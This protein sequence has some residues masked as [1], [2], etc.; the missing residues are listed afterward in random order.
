MGRVTNKTALTRSLETG[1]IEFCIFIIMTASKKTI[2]NIVE[3]IS[4]WGE[5]LTYPLPADQLILEWEQVLND[6]LVKNKFKEP[7]CQKNLERVKSSTIDLYLENNKEAVKKE[8]AQQVKL[9][10]NDIQEK[11]EGITKIKD[12]LEIVEQASADSTERFKRI[13]FEFVGH[14]KDQKDLEKIVEEFEEELIQICTVSKPYLFEQINSIIQEESLKFFQRFQDLVI[15][16]IKKTAKEQYAEVM[17]FIEIAQ[18]DLKVFADEEFQGFPDVWLKHYNKLLENQIIE[19]WMHKRD[20]DFQSLEANFRTFLQTVLQKIKNQEIVAFDSSLC[21]R[22]TKEAVSEV[23]LSFFPDKIDFPCLTL[24]IFLNLTGVSCEEFIKRFLRNTK[25]LDSSVSKFLD[26]SSQISRFFCI[27]SLVLVFSNTYK[28]LSDNSRSTEDPFNPYY[29]QLIRL[30]VSELFQL[31]Y[32]SLFHYKQTC[33]EWSLVLICEQ[34]I[35]GCIPNWMIEDNVINMT[36][37]IRTNY[38]SKVRN[39]SDRIEDY[40]NEPDKNKVLQKTLQITSKFFKS[41][42]PSKRIKQFSLEKIK[43][44][45]SL[46]TTIVI[47]GWLSQEDEMEESWINLISSKLQGHTFALRWDS[48]SSKKMVKKELFSTVIHSI[49]FIVA[50]PILKVAHLA[51]LFSS[52][53]FKKRAKK[54]ETTGY[55]LADLIASKRLGNAC[56]NLVGFS[57]GTRVIY[58]CLQ[59]LREIGC[60]VNDVLLLGGAAPLDVKVWEQ[61][62]DVVTGR[63]VNTFSKTDKVLSKLYSISRLEKAIGNWPL[64]VKGV[65]NFDVT[66]EASG[67]LKYRE[68]IDKILVKIDYFLR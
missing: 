41:F 37:F 20:D 5:S 38:D 9:I 62:K 6:Q 7:L 27:I 31:N 3:K 66:D 33:N 49:G 45:P 46:T 44:C 22:E 40:A 67:H 18:R 26:N 23:V 21:T 50:A 4:S 56:V 60:C 39:F 28:V 17:G 68:N 34:E 2:K 64:M 55:V 25:F 61:C 47:S 8:L 52:N 19:Y 1:I 32:E 51:W 59:R 12:F 11:S 57:L 15:E 65:E 29:R 43:N 54:A 14:E 16:V 53:P 36:E 30:V 10:M 48:G 35:V 24:D 63:L 58:F 13:Y 42:A